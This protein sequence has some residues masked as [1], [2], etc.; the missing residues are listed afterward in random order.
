M[1]EFYGVDCWAK[2]KS[3][4]ADV[5]GSNF[6]NVTNDT[7]GKRRKKGP[8]FTKLSDEFGRPMAFRDS[9]VSPSSKTVAY[10]Y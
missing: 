1:D 5:L 6:N 3:E 8:R 9:V 2:R 10:Y 4:R 7:D